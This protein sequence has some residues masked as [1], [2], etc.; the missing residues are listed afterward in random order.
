VRVVAS[1]VGI[2]ASQLSRIER[3]ERSYTRDVGRRLANYYGVSPESL[4]LLEGRVPAD[5]AAILR[6]HPEEVTRL[7]EQF[8]GLGAGEHVDNGSAD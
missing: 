5:I 2:A 6:D 3:G 1:E 7:R 8:G 4:E